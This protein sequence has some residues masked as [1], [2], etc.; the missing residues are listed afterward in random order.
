MLPEI[1]FEVDDLGIVTFI[2][3]RALELTGYTHAD[4]DAGFPA[5]DVLA[6]EDR[7][8]AIINMTRVLKG[9][10]IERNAYRVRCKDG[11]CFPVISTS[12]PIIRDGRSVGVRG[13]LVSM[14]AANAGAEP[15]LARLHESVTELVP[16]WERMH[17]RLAELTVLARLV[18][19]GTGD[20][21][22]AA[23]RREHDLDGA[24]SEIPALTSGITES[25]RRTLAA[26]E[27]LETQR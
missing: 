15:A 2:N 8:R 18:E 21:R 14:D 16:A 3:E 11:S 25:L 27:S 7:N 13:I 17:E 4:V 6:P 22:L 10:Q 19:S 20:E 1:V 12:L 9:E 26:L 23:Y 5:I 24:L